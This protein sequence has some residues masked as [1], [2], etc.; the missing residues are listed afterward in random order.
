MIIFMYNAIGILGDFFVLAAYFLL[1][2]RKLKAES[3]TYS[4]LNLIGA[5][6]ILFSLC[7]AWNLPAAIVESAWALLSLYGLFQAVRSYYHQKGNTT[8]G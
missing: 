5:L 4:L 1:Q 2:F 6:F 8:H 3:I 7:F